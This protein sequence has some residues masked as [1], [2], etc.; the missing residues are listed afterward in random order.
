MFNTSTNQD[1]LPA[2]RNAHPSSISNTLWGG[3]PDM[4]RM[5]DRLFHGFDQTLTSTPWRAPLAVWEDQEHFYVEVELA[6][7]SQD[8]LDVSVEKRQLLITYER[9]VPENKQFTYNERSYGRFERRL[10][11]PDSVD[12]NSITAEM[13]DG[14]LQVKLAKLPQA[15]PRKIAVQVS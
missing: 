8:A 15:Q 7:I 1:Q 6:E 13:K 4:D 12:V 10:V 2:V 3:L 9:N 5:F 14:L 11:L